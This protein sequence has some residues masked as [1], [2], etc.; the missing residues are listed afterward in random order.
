MS[1]AVAALRVAAFVANSIL[2]SRREEKRSQQTLETRQ[3]QMFMDIYRQTTSKDYIASWNRVYEDSDWNNAAEF[4]ELW[5]DNGFRESFN[6]VGTFYEGVGV[7]VREGYLSIRLVAL[8]ICGMTLSYWGKVQPIIEELRLAFDTSRF[9]S[10]SEYLYVELVKYL[11]AH[12]ELQTNA[13][14]PFKKA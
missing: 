3:A 12:P 4:M 1:V 6:V 10:E 7:L 8:L 14:K 2:V 13:Y 5:K 9:L 11:E